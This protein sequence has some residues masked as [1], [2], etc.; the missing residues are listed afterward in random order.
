MLL[1]SLLRLVASTRNPGQPSSLRAGLESGGGA[2]L[3]LFAGALRLCAAQEIV[4]LCL[5]AAQEIVA[6]ALEES[7]RSSSSTLTLADFCQVSFAP[8]PSTRAPKHVLLGQSVRPWLPIHDVAS[9][10]R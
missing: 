3:L 7:G 8:R 5:Y 2:L 6:R 10:G 1:H 9:R 4:A